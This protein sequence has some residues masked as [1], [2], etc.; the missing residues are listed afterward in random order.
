M[1]PAPP[2]GRENRLLARVMRLL[3]Q[4]MPH[5]ALGFFNIPFVAG[6]DMNVD[7][8]DALSGRR[9]HIDADVVA[10]RFER[11]IKMFFFLFD[12]MH[13][14][15][16]FFRCQVEETGDMPTRDDQCVPRTHRVGVACAVSKLMLYRHPAR[17]LAKQAGIIGVSFLF[18]CCFRRQLDTSF[19][20]LY[21]SKQSC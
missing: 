3:W 17:V 6:D 11:I 5:P 15:R 14:G 12:E 13:A 19:C 16:D 2:E 9:A 1:E 21:S 20:T 7:M 10:I 4:H 8:E 18:L